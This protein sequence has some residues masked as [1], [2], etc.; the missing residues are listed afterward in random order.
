MC[1]ASM[2]SKNRQKGGGRGVSDS[3]IQID[4]YSFGAIPLLLINHFDSFQ[5]IVFEADL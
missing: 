2:L 5:A 3:N 1:G 4:S